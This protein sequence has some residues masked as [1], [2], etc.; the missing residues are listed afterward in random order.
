MPRQFT[1]P[2]D[3]EYEFI[4]KPK[5]NDRS[6]VSSELLFFSQ[7]AIALEGLGYSESLISQQIVEVPEAPEAPINSRP[8]HDEEM[9]LSDKIKQ[10]FL[11]FFED[12]EEEDQEKPDEDGLPATAI[13]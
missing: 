3:T 12:K 10:I 9:E 8:Q 6:D 2:D 5:S 1:P 11:R 13:M 4:E 7:R